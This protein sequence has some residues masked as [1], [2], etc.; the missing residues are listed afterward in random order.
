MKIQ[1]AIFCIF[2]FGRL[3]SQVEINDLQVIEIPEAY[4]EHS[5]EPLEVKKDSLYIF[6]TSEVFLVNKKSFSAIKNVYQSTIN[7]DKM[8]KELV[9]KYTQTLKRNMDLERKLVANFGKSDSL[10]AVVYQK[11][12][13]TLAHT[14]KALDYTVNSLENASKSLELVEKARKQQRT[15]SIFEKILIGI[16]GIGAGVLVGVSL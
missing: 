3:F 16:A 13:A 15:K 6:K 11:T 10:D 7:K 12:Q 1:V 5:G 9:D 4:A 14:Q 8:T 2:T